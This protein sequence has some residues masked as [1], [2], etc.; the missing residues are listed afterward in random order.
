MNLKVKSKGIR[1]LFAGLILLLIS[2][3]STGTYA[4][5]TVKTNPLVNL[6]HPAIVSCDI[7]ETFQ[8]NVKTDVFVKNTGEIPAYIRSTVVVSFK[9][10]DGSVSSQIPEEGKDYTIEYNLT[11]DG[12]SPGADGCYYWKNPVPVKGQ[13]GVLIKKAEMKTG[14][15]PPSGYHLSVEVLAEAIQ[16]DPASAKEEAW[17]A[18]AL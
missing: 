13:T 8:S 6:F 7:N 2:L 11:S 5:L 12:W 10:A 15:T 17:G 14:A 16:S 18:G 3:T 4:F 1:L 9:A